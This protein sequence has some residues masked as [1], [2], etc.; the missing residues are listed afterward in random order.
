MMQSQQLNYANRQPPSQ[1]YQ[2]GSFSTLDPTRMT[3][4]EVRGTPYGSFPGKPSVP[5]TTKAAI[6]QGSFRRRMNLLP[7]LLNVLIPCCLFSGLFWVVSFEMHYKNPLTAGFLIA[8]A[9][10][11]VLSLGCMA[12]DKTYRRLRGDATQEPTWFVFLFASCALALVAALFF[13]Q[14]NFQVNLQPY[15]DIANLNSYLNVDPVGARGAEYMD[16]GRIVFSEGA[17]LDVSRSMGFKSKETYCVAP[18]TSGGDGSNASQLMVYDFWAIG[19]DCCAGSQ[20]GDFRCGSYLDRRARG[21]L[22]LMNDEMRPF[23]RLAVQ[24]AEAAY[25]IKAVHPIFL[26]WMPNPVEEVNQYQTD[27]VRYYT[28]GILCHLLAQLFLVF[29]ALVVFSKIGSA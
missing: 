6:N 22:R 5:L 25:N 20:G 8:V 2:Q 15:Y 21:G 29:T 24:Q 11:F 13:G 7:M 19:T 26:Y 14:N 17:K 4:P 9:L 18:V 16:A 27:G 3:P 10:V 28:A 1:A 12:V 23:F